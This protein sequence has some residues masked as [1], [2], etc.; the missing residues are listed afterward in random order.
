MLNN[1]SNTLKPIKTYHISLFI[2]L[3]MK[4][5]CDQML[6]TCATWLRLL[7]F[8]T[9]YTNSN[10]TDDELLRIAEQE[11]RWV[12]S[13]DKELLFRARKRDMKVCEITTTELD[14]QLYQI[15]KLIPLDNH[16]LLSRCTLCNSILQAIDKESVKGKIPQQSYQTYDEF[17]VCLPCLKYYWKGSHYQKIMKKIKEIK[18]KTQSLD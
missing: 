7:G 9:F 6:G 11:N 10:I 2:A 16:H 8:D 4:L 18:K 3:T 5:L 12:I 14:E 17:W 15:L 13:R 1:T